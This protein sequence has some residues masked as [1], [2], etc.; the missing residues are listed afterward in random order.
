[1]F[2][3][4]RETVYLESTSVFMLIVRWWKP[5]LVVTLIAALASLIF[6]GPSFITPKFRS[7]VVF[8]PAAT[9]SISKAIL[10]SSGAENQDILAFG[11]EKQAEQMLQILKSDEIRNSIIKK[12]DLINHYEIDPTE[13]FPQT[14]LNEEFRDNINFSR[15]EFMSIRIDVLDHNPIIASAIANEI[16]SLLDTMKSKIQ[17][18]RASAA[19]QI[20]EQTYQE[21]LDVIKIKEDSLTKLRNFGVMDFSNQSAIWSEEYARAFSTYNNEVAALSV[22]NKYLKE[23]DTTVINT[24]ARIEGANARMKQLQPRLDRMAAFGG[25]SVSLNE[26]LTLD[27]K[28]LSV[29]KEQYNRLKID[30]RQTLSHTF[31]VNKAEPAEKKAYPTRWLIVLLSSTGAFLLALTILLT[32]EKLKEI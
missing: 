26:E 30:A 17:H 31:I 18:S 19:L 13:D 23:T 12:F 4:A 25:A 28:E 15:T 27:R 6:S 14:R 16:Y 29:L 32:K 1:M 10:E 7:T 20:V 5:L 24:K 8:F 3:K 22:L 9:N 21:K 11:A 2:Q